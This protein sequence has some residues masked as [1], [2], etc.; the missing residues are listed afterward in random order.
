MT[1][2]PAWRVLLGYVRPFRAVLVA[3]AVLSLATSATGLVLPLVVREL[4]GGLGS[5]RSVTW[6]LVL[7]VVL[8]LANTALGALGSYLLE[9]TAESVVLTTRRRLV[10]RLVRLRIPALDETEPGDLMSRVS[11]DTTLLRDVST[12]SL[13]SAITATVTLVATCTLMALLD[14]LLLVVTLAA[15]GLAQ[16][17]ISVV[18]PRIARAARH[19]QDSVGLM[20]AALERMLGAL[21][22]V[23]AAGAEDRERERLHEAAGRRGRVA[24]GRPSGRRWPA[25]PVDWRSRCR[26][27]WCSA[28]AARGSSPAR[29]TSARSSRSCCTCTT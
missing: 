25:T 1:D 19:A 10:S 29:S 28:W 8:V 27:S 13:F 17:V 18:V 14:P 26:S 12:Q 21:R 6:L 24:S 7:M 9:R 16:V 3:G 20:G 23:K 22:T 5:H 4:L 11:A 2:G 15:L